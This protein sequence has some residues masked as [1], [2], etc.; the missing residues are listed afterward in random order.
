MERAALPMVGSTDHHGPVQPVVDRF[1]GR[2][3]KEGAGMTRREVREPGT[4]ASK[5]FRTYGVRRTPRGAHEGALED[6]FE[7]IGPAKAHEAAKGALR[8][9]GR[10]IN[11]NARHGCYCVIRNVEPLA[12]GRCAVTALEYEPADQYV[13]ERVNELVT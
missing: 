3:G 8:V 11:Q 5:V 13:R 10:G 9:S 6:G 12:Q 1:A 2:F 4:L 7:P